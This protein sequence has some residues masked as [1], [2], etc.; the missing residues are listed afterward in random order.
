MSTNDDNTKTAVAIATMQRDIA[1]INTSMIEIKTLLNVY[2]TKQE[3]AASMKEVEGLVYKFDSRAMNSIKDID[4]KIENQLAPI[5]EDMDNRK[6]DRKTMSWYV[7]AALI[8]GVFN[9]VFTIA[10]DLLHR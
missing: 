5:I 2:A 8:A 4:V 6:K 1:F 7:I 3:L 10:K 9:L